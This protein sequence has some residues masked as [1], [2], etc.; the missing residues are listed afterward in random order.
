MHQIS[1]GLR[2]KGKKLINDY[3]GIYVIVCLIF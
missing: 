1:N 2:V 3:M